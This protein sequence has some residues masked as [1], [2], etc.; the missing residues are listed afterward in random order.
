MR[1]QCFMCNRKNEDLYYCKVFDIYFCFECLQY[2]MIAIEC[3]DFCSYCL[4]ESY[5][6]LPKIWTG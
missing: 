2:H 1:K 3:D 6:T 4:Y 5:I